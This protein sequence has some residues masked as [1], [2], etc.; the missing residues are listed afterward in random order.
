MELKR[1]IVTEKHQKRLNKIIDILASCKTGK[2]LLEFCEYTLEKKDSDLA[3]G[4]IARKERRE[5]P[6]LPRG[7]FSYNVLFGFFKIEVNPTYSDEFLACALAHELVH[8]IQANYLSYM[9]SFFMEESKDLQYSYFIWP[10][11]AAYKMTRI[12]ALEL[13][14]REAELMS[15]EHG[16]ELVDMLN[17]RYRLRY[18]GKGS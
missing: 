12:V 15:I 13:N 5:N 2:K 16:Q 7:L 8:F 1:I 18:L 9:N 10:E 6:K 17:C 11:F 4:L 14:L 3:L